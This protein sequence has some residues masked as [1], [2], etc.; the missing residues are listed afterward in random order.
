MNSHIANNKI[1]YASLVQNN[2]PPVPTGW[3]MDLRPDDVLNGFL[4][5]SLLLERR[6]G[7]VF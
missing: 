2:T 1:A 5:Y 4:L 7:V 3:N 6:R